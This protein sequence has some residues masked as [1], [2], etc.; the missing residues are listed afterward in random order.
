MRHWVTYCNPNDCSLA[1]PS[2]LALSNLRW[3][4]ELDLNPSDGV[5]EDYVVSTALTNALKELKSLVRLGLN[6]F[7]TVEDLNFSIG[8][9]LPTLRHLSTHV[10]DAPSLFTTP[11]TLESLSVNLLSLNGPRACVETLRH[12]SLGPNAFTGDSS[13]PNDSSHVLGS[14]IQQGVSPLALSLPSW[15]PSL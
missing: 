12:L 9:H 6:C 14:L 11:C 2:A 3:I 1:Q 10:L 4:T 8:T 7:D 5:F 15:T 13:P